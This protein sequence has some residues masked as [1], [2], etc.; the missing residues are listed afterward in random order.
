MAEL[1]DRA[2]VSSSESNFKENIWHNG[3]VL[4]LTTLNDN[5]IN[6]NLSNLLHTLDNPHPQN[7]D[8]FSYIT[9][10]SGNKCIVGAWHKTSTSG[11]EV[12]GK[13]YI[14]NVNTGEL[15][16]TLDNPNA[17]GTE[18]SD[19][20]GH[21]VAIDGN[22]CIVGA[23]LEESATGESA[24]G[25]AYIFDANTGNLL[26]TL[27]NPNAYGTA[28]TDYFGRHL[29]INNNRC[30]VSAYYEDDADGLNSGKAYIF[31]VNSGELLHTLDNPNI[32]NDTEYD[33]FGISVSIHNNVCIVGATQESD[34]VNYNSG[35][36]YIFDVSTGLLLHTL[37]NPN[38]YGTS[39]NDY[40]GTTVSISG[41]RCIVGASSEDDASG[42]NSGV[43]YIFD[44]VTGSLLHTLVNPNDYSTSANDYFGK[45]VS[46]SGDRCIVSAY[47]EDDAN[48]FDSGVVYVFSVNDGSLLDT[49]YNPNVHNTSASDNFGYNLNLDGDK[50]II[51]AYHEGTDGFV[52]SGRAYIYQITNSTNLE[53]IIES[54]VILHKVSELS[55]I[56]SSPEG[57]LEKV[58]ES[59]LT[60]ANSNFGRSV[61]IA[62]STLIVGAPYTDLTGLNIGRVYLFN[63]SSGNKLLTLDNPAGTNTYFGYDVAITEG[64]C[65]SGAHTQDGTNFQEG[66]AY[67]FDTRTGT[68]LHTLDNPTQQSQS[69][70]GAKLDIDGDYCVIGAE[71]Y[72][73]TYQYQGEVYVFD[74]NTGAYLRTLVNPMPTVNYSYFGQSIS[75]DGDYCIA[76][77]SVTN[78]PT[79]AEGVAHIFNF[80]TGALLRT[81]HNPTAEAGAF[82]GWRVGIKGNYCVVGGYGEDSIYTNQGAAYVFDIRDGSLV[83]TLFNPALIAEGKFGYSVS[84]NDTH[85]IISAQKSNLTND[86]EG[87]AYVY[88]L[89]TGTLSYTLRNPR[90]VAGELF[91]YDLAMDGNYM[92]V[93][94]GYVD[95]TE[96]DVGKAYLYKSK[97]STKLDD[98][99]ALV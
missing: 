76:G 48:E 8:E 73:G 54:S 34:D 21:A 32:V 94:V 56:L 36:A 40:F 50:C 85:V 7:W 2:T 97:V 10:I 86:N 16:H 44:V 46:I 43:A 59:P 60:E 12:S 87:I 96:T 42:T 71:R 49:L 66:K 19:N 18:L 62:G 92:A 25:R 24:A 52:D 3:N 82:F 63:V 6:N 78:D 17:Y 31:D 57:D 81:L 39:E 35:K 88:S 61:D 90:G 41:N 69:Y 72:T 77:A 55:K 70:F 38:V 51:G 20:F 37:V 75:M 64:K 45:Y 58:I 68:L 13:A 65:L 91:G 1:K 23:H 79:S 29:D 47:A 15:L 9:S 30:I 22:R 83:H 93:G 99:I 4:R 33:L 26:H 11:V 28:V 84:I 80:K 14:F 98:L 89:E 95:T 67:I 27:D 5:N 53:Q 74:T